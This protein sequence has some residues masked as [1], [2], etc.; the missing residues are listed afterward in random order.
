MNGGYPVVT[1]CDWI[2]EEEP[3][4]DEFPVVPPC[5]WLKEEEL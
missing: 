3:V 5:D 2:K 4:N 1:P